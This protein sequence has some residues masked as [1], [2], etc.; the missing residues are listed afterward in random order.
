[1]SISGVRIEA[2]FDIPKRF[3]YG[4]FMA[5][6]TLKNIPAEIYQRIQSAAQNNFRSL[7]QEII[8]RLNRSLDAE[9]AR[10]TALHAKWVMEALESGPA[11]PLK[12]KDLDA[13]FAAGVERASARMQVK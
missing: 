10:V 8:F 4:S 11:K 7:N 3:H 2:S 12:I 6:Y 13:A 9:E 1:M 5:E